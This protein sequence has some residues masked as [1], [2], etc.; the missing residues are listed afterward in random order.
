MLFSSG[1]LQHTVHSS[2]IAGKIVSLNFFF[3]TPIFRSRLE[4]CSNKHSNTNPFSKKCRLRIF[5]NFCLIRVTC[6]L[7]TYQASR[8]RFFSIIFHRYLNY[9]GIFL[10]RFLVTIV[11]NI[12]SSLHIVFSLCAQVAWCDVCTDF[13]DLI[14][15]DVDVDANEM[16]LYAY[17]IC[18]ISKKQLTALHVARKFH[19]FNRH[20][21]ILL[22][23]NRTEIKTVHS[24]WYIFIVQGYIHTVFSYV[25]YIVI[26][27]QEEPAIFMRKGPIRTGNKIVYLDK[28]SVI[29]QHFT[30]ADGLSRLDN[31]L[32]KR[33][34]FQSHRR[35]NWQNL[36]MRMGPKAKRCYRD[37]PFVYFSGGLIYPAV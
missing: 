20:V 17:L 32:P 35:R 12:I 11:L 31:F 36:L 25:P 18:A 6:H 23:K 10:G 34:N 26:G 1:A 29:T 7:T 28:F 21:F 37:W 14:N 3:R 8:N 19:L 16:S 33:T 13:T 27:L 9:C 4:A 15:V 30:S 2:I 24:T 22:T 5:T